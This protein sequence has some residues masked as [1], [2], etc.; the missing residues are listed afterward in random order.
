VSTTGWAEKRKRDEGGVEKD[1][2][3]L[4]PTQIGRALQELGIV[5]IAAHSPQAKGRVARNF[6]T[7]QD[8]LVKGM[9]VAGVKTIEEANTYLTNDY[10]VWWES[11]DDLPHHL[12]HG[13]IYLVRWGFET[14]NQILG[15][16]RA[17]SRRSAPRPGKGTRRED[18]APSHRPQMSSDRLF[19]DRVA[20]QQSPSLLHRHPQINM[21]FPE[22]WG[23]G[24]TSTLP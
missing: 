9:R 12:T 15:Q 18:H 2:K 19:L 13:G 1:P 21:H 23:K 14:Q 3:K 16:D 5:W 10:L 4:P 6:G 8:R 22:P 7:A 20:R 11:G 17:A 24:D